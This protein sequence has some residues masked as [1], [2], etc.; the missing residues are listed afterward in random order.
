[1]RMIAL[2]MDGRA[3][4]KA[5]DSGLWRVLQ[6]DIERIRD[7]NIPRMPLNQPLVYTYQILSSIDSIIYIYIS[8]NKYNHVYILMLSYIEMYIYNSIDE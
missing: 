3:H 7:W 4:K 1:M 6:P 2:F 8:P 5:V